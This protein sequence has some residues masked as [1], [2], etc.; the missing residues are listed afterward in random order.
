MGRNNNNN[1]DHAIIFP[2]P[3]RKILKLYLKSLIR[4]C[5]RFQMGFYNKWVVVSIEKS[6]KKKQSVLIYNIYK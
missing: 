4:P 2:D 5:L 1:K 3:Y 6:G